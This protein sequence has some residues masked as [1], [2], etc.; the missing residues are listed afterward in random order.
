MIQDASIS[1]RHLSIIELCRPLVFFYVSCHAIRVQPNKPSW[2]ICLAH[3]T[4][5]AAFHKSGRNLPVGNGLFSRQTTNAKTFSWTHPSAWISRN[6]YQQRR[7][8]RMDSTDE[9]AWTVKIRSA[10][11][12]TGTQQTS[13]NSHIGR[14]YIGL[15]RACPKAHSPRQVRITLI[16]LRIYL[17]K[18][19]RI[20]QI[21]FVLV[22]PNAANVSIKIVSI[23]QALRIPSA[24]ENR[25]TR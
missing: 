9:A 2:T 6:G 1:A 20:V 19:I 12:I 11:I 5:H 25:R 23:V 16:T 13:G 22:I 15:G 8:E 3:S 7:L 14:D 24:R 4:S 17:R 18:W 10:L 21:R